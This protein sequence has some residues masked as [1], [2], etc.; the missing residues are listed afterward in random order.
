MQPLALNL[1]RIG[2]SMIILWLFVI[3]NRTKTKIHKKDI[4]QFIGCALSGI[5]LNQVLF[6]QGLSITYSIHAALLMLITPILILIFTAIF[7]NEYITGEKAAGIILGLT[8]AAVL[9]T[10]R[11]KP[12]DG[13]DVFLGD[14]LI[15]LNA[16]SY[17]I[18]FLLVKPLMKKYRS[19]VVIR[20]IFTIGF[21]M[22]LPI[23]WNS[24]SKIP[25]NSYSM[26][27]ISVLSLIIVGGTLLA[28]IF[29]LY[30]IKILGTTVAGSYIYS[31][32]V[33]ASIIA[34]IVLKERLSFYHLLAAG[35]IFGG[36]Y[37]VNKKARNA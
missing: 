28:Y 9:I 5:A 2:A 13:V 16:V 24:F 35:L 29:N 31:Q 21:F 23:A 15:V 19:I 34:M 37:L 27:D 18:Y 7:L 33:F 11:S 30:G 1:V 36:V 22:I 3:I 25:W 32:P 20:M 4:W 17:T 12:S 14:I 8:G 6:V 10:A 26:V